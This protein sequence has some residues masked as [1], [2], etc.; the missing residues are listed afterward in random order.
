MIK[1]KSAYSLTAILLA[2]S[3]LSVMTLT[4]AAQ[5]I[6]KLQASILGSPRKTLLTQ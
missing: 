4:T 3:M 6:T 2:F 5:T 1:K